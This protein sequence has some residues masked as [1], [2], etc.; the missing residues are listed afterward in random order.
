MDYLILSYLILSTSNKISIKIAN[1]MITQ[2]CT[3]KN[4]NNAEHVLVVFGTENST[5]VRE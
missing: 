4:P 3:K 1:Q 5:L 2:Q